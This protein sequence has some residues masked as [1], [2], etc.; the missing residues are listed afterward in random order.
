MQGSSCENFG[1]AEWGKRV[2]TYIRVGR[3]SFGRSEDY[4]EKMEDNPGNSLNRN[5]PEREKCG[6]AF[7]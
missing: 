4:L 7:R 6:Y 5:T 1:V 3:L 2:L